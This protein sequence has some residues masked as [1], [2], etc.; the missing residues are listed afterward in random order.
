MTMAVLALHYQNDVV[1][2][3]GLLKVGFSEND[4]R[5]ESVLQAAAELL[6]QARSLAWPV[7][8]V[9]IAF[10]QDYADLATNI[11]AMKRVAELGAVRD[12]DWG[13]NFYEDLVPLKNQNEFLIT[14]T[15]I[16]AFHGTSLL[17]LLRIL[18]V[19]KLIVAGVATHSVVESTVR[20]AADHG[21]EVLVASDACSSAQLDLH[22][23]SLT[24]MNMIATV[25]S[26]SEAISLAKKE[27]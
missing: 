17:G 9:R 6:R 8:H 26:V 25:T 13:A 20:E 15:K 4:P 27:K 2:S 16:G 18:G 19:M 24:S 22:Y 21:F 3:N 1:H 5:R 11:P 10:R 7:I 23:A 12:G 14:H